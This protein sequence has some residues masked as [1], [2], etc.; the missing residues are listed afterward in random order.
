MSGGGAMLRVDGVRAAYGQIE[1]LRGVDLAFPGGVM[2]LL[3]A[4]GAGKSTLLKVLSGQL[5]PTAGLIWVRGRPYDGGSTADMV[6]AG[7]ALVPEGRG[8][9][10]TL[11]VEENLTLASYF[12]VPAEELLERAYALFPKLATRRTQRAGSMSGGEQQMLALGR[13]LASRPRLLLLDE[14]SMGL[15]PKIVDE[16][17]G[18]VNDEAAAGM[19]ILV[20]E[21]YADRAL[22]VAQ[23]AAVMHGGRVVAAG[24]PE[25]IRHRLEDL[26]LGGVA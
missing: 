7:V 14:L 22:Q 8:V 1:V 17:Y 11:T 6:R 25:E 5:R 20:V 9:F 24:E 26:Y 12:G 16:L 2:A 3:G 18:V 21:Q 10:P 19:A 15:A 4:N 13:A 23:T